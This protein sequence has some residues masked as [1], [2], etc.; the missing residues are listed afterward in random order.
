MKTNGK[1]KYDDEI[2]D[3]FDKTNADG[4]V[5]LVIN[6]NKGHGLSVKVKDQET[7][8]NAST[9]MKLAANQLLADALTETH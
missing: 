6:G 9:A 8:I 2:Q 1:G 5:L 7:A 3:L 4:V